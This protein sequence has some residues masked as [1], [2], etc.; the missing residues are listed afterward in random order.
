MQRILQEIMKKKKYL[1]HQMLG[2]RVICPSEAA[3]QQTSILY[4]RLT[5]FNSKSDESECMY[6]YRV[7]PK[8]LKVSL[9][10]KK[11]RGSYYH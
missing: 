10:S 3:K 5:D 11:V 6:D 2:L 9:P 8:T 4:C 1:E 7:F